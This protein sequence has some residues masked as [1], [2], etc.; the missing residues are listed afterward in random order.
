MKEII[1]YK[2]SQVAL[3]DTELLI[4]RYSKKVYKNDYCP[5][6][7]HKKHGMNNMPGRVKGGS[8]MKTRNIVLH[9]FVVERNHYAH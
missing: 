5:H 7:V 4:A 9:V 3:F 8:M 6:S 2:N 1:K